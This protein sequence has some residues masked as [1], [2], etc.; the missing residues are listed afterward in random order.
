[1][2][3]ALGGLGTM[4]LTNL[5][6]LWSSAV[7]LCFLFINLLDHVALALDISVVEFTACFPL[8][9]LLASQCI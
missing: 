5:G 8:G 6:E 2:L 4:L 3:T 9:C 7:P 1:M